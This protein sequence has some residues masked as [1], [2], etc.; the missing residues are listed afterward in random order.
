MQEG[1]FQYLDA[2]LY[3]AGQVARADQ[4]GKL[5]NPLLFAAQYLLA[6]GPAVRN[7][8]GLDQDRV[9]EMITPSRKPCRPGSLTGIPCGWACPLS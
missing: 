6:S 2:A 7:P 3:Y 4:P 1:E 9:S 5:S 8:Q